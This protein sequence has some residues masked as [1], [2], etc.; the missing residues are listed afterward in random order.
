MRSNSYSDDD[1]DD[2]YDNGI[3]NDND[4]NDDKDQPGVQNHPMH[5]SILCISE[6]ITGGGSKGHGVFPA[7]ILP[8]IEPKMFNDSLIFIKKNNSNDNN[9]INL[10]IIADNEMILVIYHQ[11]FYHSPESLAQQ[12]IYSKN[13]SF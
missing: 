4:Y 7:L 13:G 1:N 6:V 9:N 8:T 5:R 12:I 10:S 11:N 3:D 2:N